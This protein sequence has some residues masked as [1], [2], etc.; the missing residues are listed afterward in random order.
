MMIHN[1]K[2]ILEAVLKAQKI[3][4]IPHQNPDGDALGASTAFA[5]WLESLG[6]PYTFFCKTPASNRLSH[7]PLKKLTSDSSVWKEPQDLVIVFD[8]GDLRYAGVAEEV[9]KIREHITLINID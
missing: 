7:L 2:Q 6:K 4:L 3:L 5:L 1:A 8:S 9:E